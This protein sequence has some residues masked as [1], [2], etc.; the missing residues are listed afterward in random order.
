[1]MQ[2]DGFSPNGRVY[3][4]GP[5]RGYPQF[6]FPA[7]DAAKA[8]WEREGWS[9]VSPADMDRLHDNHPAEVY[10]TA[11]AST[12]PP[13]I[14]AHYM[15][16]DIAALLE[17]EAIAFLPGWEKSVGAR[18]EYTVARALGLKLLDAMTFL[19]LRVACPFGDETCSCRDRVGAAAA[20]V[21]EDWARVGA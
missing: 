18:V 16:R 19:P 21:D 2:P 9:V 10:E 13:K 3:I 12:Q 20:L 15:R 6:N 11:T 17:V 5:M 4:A 14:F 1:M 7:F 8:D